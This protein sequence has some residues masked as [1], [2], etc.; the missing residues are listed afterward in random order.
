MRV[1]QKCVQIISDVTLLRL[2][3]NVPRKPRPTGGVVN[4]L[5]SHALECLAKL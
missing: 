5:L 2:S 4:V 3:R 1:K